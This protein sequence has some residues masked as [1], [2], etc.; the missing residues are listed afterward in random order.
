[1]DAAAIESELEREQN[2][3]R[4]RTVDMKQLIDATV[5]SVRRISADLRP[6][7]LD[8]LGL[9]PT[10]E[11]LAKDFSTRTGIRADLDIPDE[12]LGVEG[13]AATAIFRIA[14]E[15]LTNVSRHAGATQVTV[16]LKR[17]SGNVVVR[18]RDNGRGLAAADSRKTRSFGVLGMRERAYVLGGELNISSP[19]QGGTQIEAVIPIFGKGRGTSP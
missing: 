6:V 10:L 7:M 15:A 11:W 2:E 9:V 13:D 14:Q 19:P 12:N 5:A 8:N 1:M 3:L 17:R 16:E 4:K 18:I